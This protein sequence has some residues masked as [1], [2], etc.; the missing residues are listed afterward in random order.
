MTSEYETT[1]NPVVTGSY[2]P[3]IRVRGNF[4]VN[5][6]P[7]GNVH[8]WLMHWDTL[9]R[10][11]MPCVMD[12]CQQCAK[13]Q[14]RRPM[15]YLAVLHRVLR[16]TDLIWMPAILEVPL[17]TGIVLTSKKHIAVALRRA[18]T[19]KR[20]EVSGFVPNTGPSTLKDFDI[21]PPLM[22]L[23]RLPSTAKLRLLDP[24][25][26]EMWNVTSD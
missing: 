17:T 5:V 13:F 20:I 6:I 4:A 24:T 2:R 16:D 23:W 12:Q 3:L 1:G 22:R 19:N 21:V 25:E 9:D 8:S 26:W 7:V 11:T 15:S 10:R 14:P 18:R